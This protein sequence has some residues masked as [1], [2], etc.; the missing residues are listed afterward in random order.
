[1]VSAQ[2]IPLPERKGFV[3][4]NILLRIKNISYPFH[5]TPICIQFNYPGT[6]EKLLLQYA[7]F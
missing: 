5:P 4:K 1:V 3:S 7:A 2:Q 6:V